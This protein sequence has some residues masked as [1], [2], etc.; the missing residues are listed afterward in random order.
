MLTDETLDKVR[1]LERDRQ[2]ARPDAGPAGDRLGAARPARDLGARRRE[3]RRSSSRTNLGA[4]AT[5]SSRPTSWRR[6]TV[7]D[8]ER[9][10]PLGRIER[11]M[12]AGLRTP[13]CDLLGIRV[14]ILLAGMAG[15]PSMPELAAA[16]T[17]AGGLGVL[18]ATGITAAGPPGCRGACA[19]ARSRM[20]RGCS[21]HSSRGGRPR[22]AS[23]RASSRS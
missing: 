12:S 1:A 15:G 22:P 2:A 8:R 20:P 17:R 4:L 9:H 13:P 3:Q 18:G 14:P 21:M 10:Q 19:R 6:S 7:R 5:S 16:V 11:R 23:A